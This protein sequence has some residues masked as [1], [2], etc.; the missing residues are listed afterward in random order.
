MLRVVLLL[1]FSVAVYAD[2]SQEGSLNTF[3]GDNSITNSNNTTTDTSTSNTYNGAGSSSEI[4]VGSAISPSYMS[5]GQDTCLKG[6]GGSLQT[7]G[8]GISSGN[9]EVDP[10]CDRRRDAKLL[11]DL[12]MKVAAVSRMCESLEV[13]KAMLMSGTPCPILQN[14][15][16][17][18]GK[19]AYLA[20][21]M[22][23]EI[24]IPDYNKKTKEWYDSIL[25]IGETVNEEQAED[26]ISVSSKFRSS[27]K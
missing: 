11:S 10:N 22:Q 8:V 26:I 7:V 12:G 14:S 9:Y 21:K 13:W 19:R 18:A 16:L 27:I 6:S 3:H 25:N 20:L 2:N 17:V 23:P 5:N 1:L 4:P 24:Y 15:R